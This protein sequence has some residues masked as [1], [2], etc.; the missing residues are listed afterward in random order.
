MNMH[1]PQDELARSEAYHIVAAPYQYLAPTSGQPLRGLIQDHNSIAVLLTKRDTF[2]TR[3]QYC[4]LVF[5]ALQS[6]PAYG[7]G[8]GSPGGDGA[9]GGWTGRPGTAPVPLLPPAVLR[10]HAL[11]T[12][13]QVVS[14]VLIALTG[15][16]L[17]ATLPGG[18]SASASATAGG[19]GTGLW[20]DGKT[21][22]GDGLWGRGY[23]A[24]DSMPLPG[25]GEAAL[26][27]RGSVIMTGVIDKN[28]L[29]NTSSGL[30]HCVYEAYG[31]AAAGALLSSTGRLL[32][33]FLQWCASTCGLDDLRLTPVADAARSGLIDGG[34][35]AGSLAGAAY[36]LGSH[37]AAE[38]LL[39]VEAAA[40]GGGKRKALPAAAGAGSTEEDPAAPVALPRPSHSSAWRRSVRLATRAK[41]RGGAAA[42]D[43]TGAA[44]TVIATELDNAVK[45]AMAGVHSKVIDACLPHGLAKTF[46]S[47]QFALMVASGAKGSSINH[48]MIAVG[49]GQQELEGR[50]VPLM[51][52]GKS[53]P[54]FPAFDP[55]PRAGEWWPWSH[56]PAAVAVCHRGDSCRP[57]AVSL[58]HRSH[59]A[60][61]ALLLP[62]FPPSLPHG[63]GAGGYIGDRFLTGLRPQEYFM[64]CMSGREGLVDTAVKTS[65]SGYLQRCLVK[66]L[67]ALRV[68]Y[69][70]TVRDADGGLVQTA[71]GEDG[72]DPLAAPFLAHTGGGA[73]GALTFLAR[74]APAVTAG[75]GFGHAAFR[76][77][78]TG[79][80]ADTTVAA[81]GAV[82]AARALA[83]VCEPPAGGRH[84]LPP[85]VASSSAAS[86]AGVAASAALA[87]HVAT[88]AGSLAAGS[89]VLVRLPL[90]WR[91]GLKGGS[92]SRAWTA[93]GAIASWPP[94]LEAL[95]PL[96]PGASPPGMAVDGRKLFAAVSASGGKASAAAAG[97]VPSVNA[98]GRWHV[99]TVTKV[100]RGDSDDG[101]E[102]A[103]PVDAVDVALTIAVPVSLDGAGAP[104]PVPGGASSDAADGGGAFP[105]GVRY[106]PVAVSVRKLPLAVALP[107]PVAGAG[108]SSSTAAAAESSSALLVRP[109]GVPDPVQSALPPASHLGSL[110]E[111]LLGK[112]AAYSERN[113]GGALRV[114]ASGKPGAT[115]TLSANNFRLLMFVKGL[116]SLA[117]PGEPVGVLAAQGV[118]EPSTQMTLNTFHLAGGGGV[119]VTLGIPRLR[120]LIMTA[121]AAIKTPAMT[122]PISHAHAPGASGK[123]GAPPPPAAASLARRLC[124]LPLASVLDVGRA[125][126]GI[127]VTETLRPLGSGGA[128]GGGDSALE[129]AAYGDT[130]WVREYAVRLHFAPLEAIAASFGAGAGGGLNFARLAAVV[131]SGFTPKLLKMIA[132]D[133]RKAARAAGGS[134][135][136]ASAVAAAAAATGVAA[137][138]RDPGAPGGAAAVKDEDGG[139]DA[140]A[141]S[142]AG[143]AKKGGKSKSAAASGGGGKKP[144]KARVADADDEDDDAD[145]DEDDDAP[146]DADGT[147]RTKTR[148]ELEGYDDDEE[149]DKSA[150]GSDDD[151]EGG[152]GADSD[153]DSD[154]GFARSGKKGG[155]STKKASAGKKGGKAAA[156]AKKGGKAAAAAPA[157]RK[158]A[159]AA[160]DSDDDEAAGSGEASDAR[161]VS[162]SSSS[163][164]GASSS[165]R[166][167]SDAESSSGDDNEPRRPSASSA[168]AAAASGGK[169]KRLTSKAL[170]R[171]YATA[172]AND[173]KAASV[174]VRGGKRGAGASSSADADLAAL[175]DEE[176]GASSSSLVAWVDRGSGTFRVDVP[177]AVLKH[178]RF[179]G[180]I[181]CETGTYGGSSG[182]GSSEGGA[183]S[184][185]VQLTLA[186]PASSRKVLMLASAER[187]AGA[188]LVASVPGIG[189]ALAT[190]GRLPSPLPGGGPEERALVVTEGVNLH[191]LWAAAA[192]AA[193]VPAPG[194]GGV[195]APLI[196]IN[197]LGTNDIAAVLRTY[198]VEAARAGLLRE[199][200]AVFDAYGIAL[201]QRHLAL[202]SDYMTFGCVEVAV[203]V[204]GSSTPWCGGGFGWERDS[205]SSHT[206]PITHQVQRI[207]SRAPCFSPSPPLLQWRLHAHEPTGHRR[208]ALVALPA[209][210]VRDDHQVPHVGADGRR[211]RGHDFAVGAP[212]HGPRR[213]LGHGVLRPVGAAGARAARCVRVSAAVVAVAAPHAATTRTHTR[214]R[215]CFSQS[216]G[217]P[218]LCV[219]VCVGTQLCCRCATAR[220]SDRQ[221]R[222]SISVLS[223]FWNVARSRNN[224]LV[225]RRRVCARAGRA[226]PEERRE[227]PAR[228]ALPACRVAAP[229]H[230]IS[231][232][233]HVVATSTRV[234]EDRLARG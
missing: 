132:D 227:T 68:H 80:H 30:T 71:Y 203:V 109:A 188:T 149:E 76:S 40:G 186:F 41:L 39:I 104:V 130:Q 174:P 157:R 102:A 171:A 152:S 234:A 31:P 78:V 118:G 177:E 7:V 214:T 83:A 231:D 140:D 160:S 116:R 28:A 88:F 72:L 217:A 216:N 168:A 122:I 138:K 212:G 204:E 156:A 194:G 103:G 29:G 65:R 154:A 67:E 66:H 176:G 47:N 85:T 153:D 89:R 107:P 115:G 179:A 12:G 183:P 145:G 24:K 43:V 19:S 178:P 55:S 110:G 192:E 57:H 17:N 144:A 181:A 53:L 150:A 172:A 6:L 201:D 139:D 16:T 26:T 151:D 52:S 199:L 105:S 46:P 35:D 136:A 108:A 221:G 20:M 49:L 135:S 1:L 8:N 73:D 98:S 128:A 37:A 9:H 97:A 202:I 228:A 146:R 187:A 58:Q 127:T 189:R 22:I 5:S 90:D 230:R 162:S 25:L 63:T 51:P 32:T 4:Q 185:W 213:R 106:A 81:A 36:A 69:D 142:E 11:W 70:G 180:V 61:P 10:P 62:A 166:D 133:A 207:L 38:A 23:G 161:S 99:A 218:R 198:G 137:A 131:A 220:A 60:F 225:W 3:D 96:P 112:I 173:L 114:A 210:V 123:G 184:P 86:P 200:R 163:S 95:A 147:L 75:L 82:A 164:S 119:N 117:A 44:A 193:A 224:A 48:A 155:K 159:A 175:D 87:P 191:A 226:R 21:K 34:A 219:R 124:P 42:G 197:R 169:K 91:A 134:G 79:M 2:L 233:M 125:D 84:S 195:V 54:C 129:A 15:A 196:D 45:G 141:A 167:S 223:Q 113:P 222:R 170:Q 190:V 121:S 148:G 126:G 120:E 182:A 14:T 211:A 18:G 143:G 50:R 158:A 206:A 229:P 33:V 74:N 64:H 205:I 232:V 93:P 94:P 59:R 27:I 92:G 13:K 101:D 56:T 208:R 111:G 100:R 77:A 215:A 209:H 165:S